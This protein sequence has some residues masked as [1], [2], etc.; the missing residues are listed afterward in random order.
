MAVENKKRGFTLLKSGIFNVFLD[1]ELIIKRFLRR[2]FSNSHDIEDISQETILRALHAEQNREIHEP[3]AFLF[4]VAKNIARKTLEKK[5]KSLIDFIEDFGEKEYLSNEPGI[6]EQLESERKMLIFWDAVS[7]LPPQCQKVFV[8]K[9]VHGYSHKEI[10]KML[11][12]S[13]STIEKHAATGLKRCSEYMDMHQ[14][15]VSTRDNL[16]EIPISKQYENFE[17]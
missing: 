5:S 13:I 7:G 14:V 16:V 6:D 1:N 3:R 11:E 4:G 17:K 9:K 10:A 15:G 2:Y 8:L 12:I